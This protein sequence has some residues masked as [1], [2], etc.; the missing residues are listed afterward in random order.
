MINTATE[1]VFIPL[2]Y[3]IKYLYLWTSFILW[4]KS[5]CTFL[6]HTVEIE[7]KVAEPVRY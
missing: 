1:R 7:L 4:K 3:D 5:D 6:I 2:W